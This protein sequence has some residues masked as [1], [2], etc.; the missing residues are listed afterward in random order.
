M[1]D[2]TLN[3]AEFALNFVARNNCEQVFKFW[4]KIFFNFYKIWFKFRAKSL[5]ETF[6]NFF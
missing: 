2:V 4:L 6:F 5:K 1:E 3:N